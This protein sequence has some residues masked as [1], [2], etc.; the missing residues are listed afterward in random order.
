MT[1]PPS[2]EGPA[3]GADQVS[4]HDRRALNDVVRFSADAA[5]L[6]ARGKDQHDGDHLLQLAAEAI[7]LKIGEAVSRMS[8]QVI[9]THPEIR[10]RKMKD[11]RNLVVHN[12]EIVD[13]EVVWNTLAVELPK[14]LAKIRALLAG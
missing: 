3:D 9:A 14:D 7:V 8:D 2:A 4:D 5:E 13:A 12:Y 11:M 1:P 6:V 10:L